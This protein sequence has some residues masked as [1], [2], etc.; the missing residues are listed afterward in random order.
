MQ[1]KRRFNHIALVDYLYTFNSSNMFLIQATAWCIP[2]ILL[3]NPFNGVVRGFGLLPG[4]L[5]VNWI[6]F[7]RRI[8]LKPYLY[9]LSIV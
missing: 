2:S 9:K 7:E 1:T 4:E 6:A 8:H 5:E 3:G